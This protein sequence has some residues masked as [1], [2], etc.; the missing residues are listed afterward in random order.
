MTKQHQD[1]MVDEVAQAVVD[2][3]DMP[4][5]LDHHPQQEG[6]TPTAAERIVSGT[7]QLSSTWKQAFPPLHPH[8]ELLASMFMLPKFHASCS[9]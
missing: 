7:S 1:E 2:D 3:D 4:V 9:T 6:V 8:L 5:V